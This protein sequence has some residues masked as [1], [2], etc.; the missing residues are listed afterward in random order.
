M[1]VLL[2]ISTAGLGLLYTTYRAFSTAIIMIAAI[3]VPLL[4][5]PMSFTYATEFNLSYFLLSSI[6]H[7]LYLAVI[8]F[9]ILMG[10][11]TASFLG[12]I[13]EQRALLSFI[14][15]ALLVIGIFTYGYTY[16]KKREQLW[17]AY[18]NQFRV[19][20]RFVEVAK[21]QDITRY[22]KIYLVSMPFSFQESMFRVY[23]N[24]SGLVVKQ[25]SAYFE[26][27]ETLLKEK[28]AVLL[29]GD[30]RNLYDITQEVKKYQFMINTC[31]NYHEEDK[32]N[33]FKELS[34]LTQKLNRLKVMTVPTFLRLTGLDI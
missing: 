22:P 18:A 25:V 21:K 7:R 10:L 23:S 4:F 9:S 2:F 29:L 14:I 1:S 27:P 34:L 16:I 17:Q 19:F 33:C 12:K 3:T 32:E 5:I 11:I 26:V 13:R 28:A 15:S 31:G 8:A 6:C 30:D 20:A 24:N